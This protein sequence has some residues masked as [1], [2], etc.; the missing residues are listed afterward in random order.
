MRSDN[1]IELIEAF[2]HNLDPL[3]YCSWESS[4]ITVYWLMAHMADIDVRGS[5]VFIS[6]PGHTTKWTVDI[7]DPDSFNKI[8]EAIKW[9]DE[10]LV[11]TFE[12]N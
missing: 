7:Y 3:F 2:I 6:G 12:D 10:H 5:K 4:D 1:L 9:F 11:H 8:E